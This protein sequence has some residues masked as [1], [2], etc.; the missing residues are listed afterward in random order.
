MSTIFLDP[1]PP[2]LSSRIILLKFKRRTT[3]DRQ[4]VNLSGFPEEE[5]EGGKGKKSHGI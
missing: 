2:F 3:Q 4:A 1:P 5:Y